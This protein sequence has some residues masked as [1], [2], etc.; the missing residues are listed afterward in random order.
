[1]GAKIVEWP[2]MSPFV[3]VLKAQGPRFDPGLA[4]SVYRTMLAIITSAVDARIKHKRT[5]ATKVNIKYF[6][7]K[8]YRV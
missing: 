1:M 6:N 4:N 3:V 5:M 7:I 8:G 2:Q